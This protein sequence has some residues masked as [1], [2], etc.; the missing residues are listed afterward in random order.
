MGL[1]N[2]DVKPQQQSGFDYGLEVL[3]KKNHFSGEVVYYDNVLKNMFLDQNVSPDPNGIYVSQITN[4]GEIANR[5]WE[6]SGTYKSG[7]HLSVYASVSIMHSAGKASG[8][9]LENLPR[10][11]AG[12]FINYRFSNCLANRTEAYSA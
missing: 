9:Q 8:N 1:S 6:F 12:L 5:G 7:R 2:P 3:D 4:G 11:T 10:H